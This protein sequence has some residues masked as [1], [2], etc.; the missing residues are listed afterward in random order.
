VDQDFERAQSFDY[1]GLVQHTPAYHRRIKFWT[2]ELCLG[3]PHLFDFVMTVLNLLNV[4][5]IP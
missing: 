3:Q 5:D 4:I 2:P 1:E